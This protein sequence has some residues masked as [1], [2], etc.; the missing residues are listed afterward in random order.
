M[1]IGGGRGEGEDDPICE[2]CKASRPEL[3]RAR[4]V[5]PRGAWGAV[6]GFKYVCVYICTSTPQLS[7][8]FWVF[9]Q[10]RG[11]VDSKEPPIPQDRGL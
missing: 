9:V 8:S 11:G 6:R 4:P 5:A 7:G 10:V 2:R 1:Q 3:R